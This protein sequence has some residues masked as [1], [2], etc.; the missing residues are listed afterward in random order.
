MLTDPLQDQLLK[1]WAWFG[2]MGAVSAV[3]CGHARGPGK[4]L[5]STRHRLRRWAGTTPAA[6]PAEVCEE[7]GEP[8]GN[9]PS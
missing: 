8:S 6:D 2:L 7:A 1:F 4:R 5:W 9:T 3:I